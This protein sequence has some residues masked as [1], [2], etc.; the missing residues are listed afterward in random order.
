M[1]G[2]ADLIIKGE[3]GRRVSRIAEFVRL[4]Q[5]KG[6][7]SGDETLNADLIVWRPDTRQK[8]S[9][10]GRMLA[11]MLR[12]VGRFWGFG[13][14]QR[15][16]ATF[17]PTRSGP[18]VHRRQFAQVADLLEVFGLQSRLRGRPPPALSPPDIERACLRLKQ[19]SC[20]VDIGGDPSPIGRGW[21]EGFAPRLDVATPTG[22]PWRRRD[23]VVV[24]A[25][26]GD[27]PLNGRGEAVRC[28][29][30]KL[31]TILI[32]GRLIHRVANRELP[33]A[34]T[35]PRLAGGHWSDNL[36]QGRERP[37]VRPP[38]ITG[39]ERASASHQGCACRLKRRARRRML[40]AG[41]LRLAAAACR[42]GA[43]AAPAC[44][45]AIPRCPLPARVLAAR[46]TMS[47]SKQDL[48]LKGHPVPPTATPVDK[49]PLDKIKRAPPRLQDRSGFERRGNP[50]G[51]PW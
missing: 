37:D 51:A 33:A 7:K 47:V 15:A 1:S 44:V 50:A 30:I 38:G 9:A 48:N 2:C 27:P 23:A 21:G 19:L 11:T 3:V 32:C 22:S 10:V 13:D 45:R 16:A 12:G 46:Q 29:T 26:M 49:L 35:P 17:S 24:N 43:A 4:C 14:G 25:R 5:G 40:V 39:G 8:R 36:P 42:S 41:S 31:Q 34:V 18:L 20:I 28:A 6:M